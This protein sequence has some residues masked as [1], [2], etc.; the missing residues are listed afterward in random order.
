MAAIL[1]EKIW[2]AEG[3]QKRAAVQQMFA[4]I[5]PRY[6]LL[7]GLMSLSLHKRWRSHAVSLLRLPT[8]G[9][10]ID[11]CSGTGDFLQPL[12]R[13][14]GEAGRVHGVD[15]CEAMVRRARAK[16]GPLLSLGDACQLPIQSGCA[17]AVSVGWGIRNVSDIDL[18]HREIHRILKPGGRF[19]SLDMAVPR[20]GLIRAGSN[21]V[22]KQ[23]L[24][25]LGALFGCAQAYT[26]LPEST[27]RFKSREQLSAS[28]AE[29]GFT[30]VGFKDLFFGIICI[31]YGKKAG[32][33]IL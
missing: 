5:A 22:S 8:G 32:P 33:E 12:R 6:D 4:D 1:G 18:A 2:T 31:H 13:E 27:E 28:M 3:S 29:A 11:V 21:F 16:V 24:P 17:D 26:Y 19:V 15:F 14:V 30:E 7:N 23:V 20:N 25:R 9:T 10:A